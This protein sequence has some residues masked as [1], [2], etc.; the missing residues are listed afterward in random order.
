LF[1]F[2][3][4]AGSFGVAAFAGVVLLDGGLDEWDEVRWMEAAPVTLKPRRRASAT[5][6]STVVMFAAESVVISGR[7]VVFICSFLAGA[8]HAKA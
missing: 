2:Q 1:P 6:D 3:V 7:F 4:F 5:R 8:E